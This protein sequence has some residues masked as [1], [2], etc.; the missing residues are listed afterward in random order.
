VQEQ[1][2]VSV[3]EILGHPGQFRD[4]TIEAPLSDV[5]NALGR[6]TDEPVKGRLRAE[7][8]V[9]GI[10]VT[11]RVQAQAGFDCARCLKPVPAT[12][13]VELCELY[14]APGHEAPPEEESY[15]VEGLEI[16]LEPMLRDAV[17]LAMPLK[18][19]CSEDCKGICATCGKDLNTGGC[20]CSEEELDPRWAALSDLRDKL[21]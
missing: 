4:L 17:A 13:E 8:V 11:G 7:S 18:P 21:A 15:R 12:L 6:L 2:K 19:V 5:R 20:G 3:A 10:L 16:D 14:T 1:F 9:E